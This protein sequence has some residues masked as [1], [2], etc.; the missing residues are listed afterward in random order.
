LK[1]SE[2]TRRLQ[3]LGVRRLAQGRQHEVW[4][5]I[6]LQV[7]AMIPR[8]PTREVPAG[9]LARILKD[10]QIDQVAFLRG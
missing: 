7:T 8:H 5:R 9:M 1:Y 2:L 3:K 10:L 6:D 4:G